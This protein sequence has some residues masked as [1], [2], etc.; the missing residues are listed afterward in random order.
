ME[1]EKKIEF[2]IFVFLKKHLEYLRIY[3]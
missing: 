3:W 1:F 2:Q